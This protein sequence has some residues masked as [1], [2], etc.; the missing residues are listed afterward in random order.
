MTLEGGNDCPN[1]GAKKFYTV[2]SSVIQCLKVPRH[3]SPLLQ[4]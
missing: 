3:T 1:K 4:L 2:M